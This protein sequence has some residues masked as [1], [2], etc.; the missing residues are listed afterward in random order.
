MSKIIIE[1]KLSNWIK[2]SIYKHVQN[3]KNKEGQTLRDKHKVTH[4]TS[5]G[6]LLRTLQQCWALESGQVGLYS[7]AGGLAS[8]ATTVLAFIF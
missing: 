8:G 3:F 1:G 2:I 6:P 7:R 4:G 5:L